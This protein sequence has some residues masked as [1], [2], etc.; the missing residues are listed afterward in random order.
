MA[1]LNT[2][3]LE[4]AHSML[5]KTYQRVFD[6]RLE[7]MRTGTFQDLDNFHCWHCMKHFKKAEWMRGFPDN[8][9]VKADTYFQTRQRT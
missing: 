7:K 9:W 8:E 4:T 2:V 3:P 1:D 5:L 6:T